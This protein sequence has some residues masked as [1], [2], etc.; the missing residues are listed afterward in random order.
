MEA[1]NSLQVALRLRVIALLCVTFSLTSCV[2]RPWGGVRR[3]PSG[4]HVPASWSGYATGPSTY[5]MPL[6]F[7]VL[8]VEDGDT[9][10]RKHLRFWPNGRVAMWFAGSER[11][12]ARQ[13]DLELA[14]AGRYQIVKEGLRMEIVLTD[15]S[16]QWYFHRYRATLG[17]D[18]KLEVRRA[19]EPLDFEPNKPTT[20]KPVDADLDDFVPQW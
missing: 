14:C 12:V 1:T 4:T 18:R 15:G 6:R 17:D 11:E 20:F 19:E 8:Y 16:N 2:P 3:D 5:S 7:D 10:V 9:E 13:E